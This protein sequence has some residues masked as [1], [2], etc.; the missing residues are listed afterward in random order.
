[1]ALVNVKHQF[2]DVSK[3]P[4]IKIMPTTNR[5]NPTINHASQP[6]IRLDN[7]F[8]IPNAVNPTPITAITK[9]AS[10]IATSRIARLISRSMDFLTPLNACCMIA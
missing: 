4:S 5:N 6:G 8:T 10:T 2:R 7:H 9:P 1:M 3:A